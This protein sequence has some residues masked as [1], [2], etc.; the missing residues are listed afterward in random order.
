MC[1]LSLPNLIDQRVL[2]DFHFQGSKPSNVFEIYLEKG[3]IDN[4]A[5][6]QDKQATTALKWTA[7]PSP[8][9]EFMWWLVIRGEASRLDIHLC[10]SKISTK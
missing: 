4:Y 2:V 5:L 7:V 8:F 1:L 6:G 10:A 3:H 9:E